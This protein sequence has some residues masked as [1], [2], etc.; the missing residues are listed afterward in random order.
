[1]ANPYEGM[2]E[3][4]Q[5]L[6][7]I[8][9]PLGVAVA[10]MIPYIEGEGAAGIGIILGINP[11]VAALAAMA[12][13]FLSVLAVVVISSRVREKVVAGRGGEDRAADPASAAPSA[14]RV[15]GQ[16]RL[17]GWLSRFGVPGASLLA[18]LALPTQLTA[19]F[20]AASGVRKERVLFWQAIAIVLWTGGIA[21][22][23]TG[24]VGVLGW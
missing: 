16:R 21:V 22:L 20:F 2:Q 24:L 4:V 18:P 14:R 11:V 7:E 6:P 5:Q 3:W 19:A 12:G 9:Q 10:G 17:Q 15:K 1:M 23:A 8:V 13:N